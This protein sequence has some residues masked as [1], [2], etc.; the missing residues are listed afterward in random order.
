MIKKIGL[1]LLAASIVITA[2]AGVISSAVHAGEKVAT[3][4]G[5]VWNWKAGAASTIINGIYNA[6]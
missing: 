6:L 1:A 5:D 4:A 2:Q 3:G